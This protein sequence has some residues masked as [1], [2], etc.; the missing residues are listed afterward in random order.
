MTSGDQFRPAGPPALNS[1]KYTAA[2]NEVKELGADNSTSRTAEET[3]IARFWADSSVPHWNR[4]AATVSEDQSLTLSQSAR[5]FALMNLAT[6]DAYISSFEAKYVFNFWRPIT[7]IRAADT[8]GNDDTVADA[9]WTPLIVNPQ[10]PAYASGHSTFGGA[11]AVVLAGFFGTDDIAFTSTSDFI[12]GVTRSFTSFSKAADENAR[13]RLLAGIHWSFDNVDGL[14]AG[15]ALGAY[16]MGNFL[17]PTL[18]L[19]EVTAAAAPVRTHQVQSLLNL[20][21]PHWQAA[22]ANTWPLQSIHVRIADLGG[23]TLRRADDGAI[24]AGGMQEPLGAAR[25]TVATVTTMAG[26]R[27][28]A[29]ATLF[30][31]NLDALDALGLGDL[32][33]PFGEQEQPENVK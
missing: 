31:W 15:R 22:G 23:G 10:M 16:V 18:G 4:I 24:Y 29:A 9:N 2:F 1:A 28:E 12:P 14:A 32:A 33:N 6:A 30:V 21:L 27:P 19:D 3:E 5:L 26:E 20:A 8:D 25:R 13:S 7:A 17:T 11:A